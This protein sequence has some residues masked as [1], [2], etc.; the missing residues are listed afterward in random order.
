MR[1]SDEI[2]TLGVISD[3]HG[4]LDSQ[5]FLLFDGVQAIVHAGDVG[6]RDILIDLQAVAP[7]FGVVGNTDG[8]DLAAQLPLRRVEE[9]E[10]IRIGIAHGHLHG[11]PSDRHS[12]LRAAFH[13][14]R[15]DVIIYGHTHRAC[16]DGDERPWVVNPGSASQGRGHGR[17]VGFLH[18]HDGQFEFE[19]VRLD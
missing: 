1:K 10:G 16:S 13:D 17:S 2:I 12:R 6:N 3:T 11:G 15:T 7:V 8:F 5:V 18:L 14:D 19:I 4:K 9:I